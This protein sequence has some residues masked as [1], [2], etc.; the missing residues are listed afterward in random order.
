MSGGFDRAVIFWDIATGKQLRK[1]GGLTVVNGTQVASFLGHKDVVTTV[2]LY[3]I[4]D[5]GSVVQRGVSCSDDMS[6]RIYD[7]TDSFGNELACLGPASAGCNPALKTA[8]TGPITSITILNVP[9]RRLLITGSEDKL[10]MIW[11]LLTY[12]RLRVLTGHIDQP[13]V[14]VG[15]TPDGSRIVTA[16]EDGKA[17]TWSSLTGEL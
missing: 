15:L 1:V 11:D 17:A 12:E 3:E 4:P 14:K 8:H 6:C 9:E 10:I 5:A 16:S 2:A 13:V 7:L